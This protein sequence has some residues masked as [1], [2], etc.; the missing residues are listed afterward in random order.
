MTLVLDASA[1]LARVLDDEAS[2]GIERVFDH[3]AAH[4]A[5][6]PSLWWLEI[7]NG[8]NVAVRRRRISSENRSVI[9]TRLAQLNIQADTETH[10]RAWDSILEIA[11]RYSLTIYDSAYLELAMRHGLPLATLDRL[12]R[13]AARSAGIVIANTL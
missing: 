4:G 3:V 7:A 10:L 8:L 11:D 2:P 1:T 13:D 6:A 9:L 12:L 5:I